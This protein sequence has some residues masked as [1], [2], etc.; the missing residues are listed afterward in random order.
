MHSHGGDVYSD[1][2]TTFFGG[3]A[4]EFWVK[5]APAPDKTEIE[6][7]RSVF[8]GGPELLDIACGAGSFTIP[9]ADA[10]YSMTGADLSDDFLRVARERAPGIDWQRTDIRELP[11]QR[12]FDGALCFGNSFG[13]FPPDETRRLLRTVEKTLKK[14]A[15]LVL[16]TAATA[17]SLLPNLQRERRIEAAGIVFS[18]RNWYHPEE[19]RL[20]TEYSFEKEDLRETKIASTWIF[21]TGGVVAMLA[22]AGFEVEEIYASAARDE[23]TV[24]SPR[25]IFVARVA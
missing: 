9:L 11:W 2:T 1:W 20:E 4:V 3:L 25:A 23:F 24:G 7:L 21:T 10:G 15:R 19:S 14:G 18:S 12:R 16:E 8:D 13:Y 17:E 5:V 6:F 22:E